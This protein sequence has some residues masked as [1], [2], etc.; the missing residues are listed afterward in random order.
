MGEP[1]NT[2]GQTQTGHL[3]K[4]KTTF[5]TR[6][7]NNNNKNDSCLLSDSSLTVGEERK[8]DL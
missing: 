8:L 4:N 2:H 3:N 1:L 7:W 5:E 6:C